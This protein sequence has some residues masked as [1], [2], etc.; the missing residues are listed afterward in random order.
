[1]GTSGAGTVVSGA[2]NANDAMRKIKE[3]ASL[4]Q[5]PLVG[6]FGPHKEWVNY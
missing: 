6:L 2:R 5:R 3:D 4:F 1:M